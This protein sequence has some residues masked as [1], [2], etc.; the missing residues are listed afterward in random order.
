MIARK[1][2]ELATND[3]NP[4]YRQIIWSAMR[5]LREFTVRD[6]EDATRLND[7]TIRT[8]IRCL[9]HAGHLA[10]LGREEPEMHLTTRANQLAS[11]RYRLVRDVGVDAPR[12]SRTG[13]PVTQGNAREQMWRTMRII[14]NFNYVDL[15]ISASTDEIAVNHEDARDYVKYLKAA[16]YLFETS[17]HGKGPSERR[18]LARYSLAP[19][20]Y[21][22]PR[23][24]QVRKNKEVY[25]PNLG[26][27]VWR[28]GG[29]E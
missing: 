4:N 10:K 25:D 27:V 5:K 14:K 13:E 1:H 22:G 24:P 12:V 15:A 28:K 7:G 29:D 2:I 19:S 18:K 3:P 26:R 17:P 23:P 6:L 21:T 8:Y 9:V 16:G 11:M 20:K